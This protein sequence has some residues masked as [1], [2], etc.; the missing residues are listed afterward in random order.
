MRGLDLKLLNPKELISENF[1]VDNKITLY[2]GDCVKLL[3]TIPSDS[4]QL[5]ITSPPYNLGKEYEKKQEIKEYFLWQKVVIKECYRVLK[6]Q[7]SMC[8]Q[9]G[10]YVE[11]GEITPLDVLLYPIFKDLNMK[12]RNRIICHFGHGL[13]ATNKFSGRYETVMWFTKSDDYYFDLDIIRVPQKYPLKKHFKGSKKGNLSCNPK[14]KN[15]S[16]IWDIPNVKSNHVEKTEHPCQF[17]IGL[18]ERLVL[19]MSK[20]DDIIL[21]PFMGSGSVFEVQFGKYAFMFYDMAKF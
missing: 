4:V 20:E 2:H 18:V 1:N 5:I 17:P 19:S 7:G 15:P 21:D 11:K 8:W 3:R 6:N 9:V 10:N 14:G 13:H 12:L 16:D